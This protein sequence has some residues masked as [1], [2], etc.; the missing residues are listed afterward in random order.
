MWGTGVFADCG[1]YSATYCRVFNK[2]C[3]RAF[4]AGTSTLSPVR[5]FHDTVRLTSK[6]PCARMPDG[7]EAPGALRA[8]QAPASRIPAASA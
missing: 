4:E 6:D 8:F 5:G 7:T 3:P 2:S 1:L